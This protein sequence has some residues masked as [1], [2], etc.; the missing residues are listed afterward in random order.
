M[1]WLLVGD[2]GG[3]VLFSY[4]PHASALIGDGTRVCVCNRDKIC[5]KI[6]NIRTPGSADFYADELLRNAYRNL[7]KTPGPALHVCENAFEARSG[8]GEV[9][10]AR[11]GANGSRNLFLPLLIN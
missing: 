1:L 4:L 3:D 5:N 8:V 11:W 6:P 7:T 2:V 9:M 10:R